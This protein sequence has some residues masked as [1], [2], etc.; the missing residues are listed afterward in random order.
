MFTL[1][2]NNFQP[3]AIVVGTSNGAVG[4]PN[5]GPDESGDNSGPAQD[6]NPPM[7]TQGAIISVLGK[8]Q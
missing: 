4:P 8:Q 6:T 7:G 1:P 5:T 3:I 2:L